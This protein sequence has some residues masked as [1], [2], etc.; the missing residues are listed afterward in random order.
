MSTIPDDVWRAIREVHE[1]LRELAEA[2]KK[3]SEEW[4]AR[5]RRTDEEI[6]NLGIHIGRVTGRW[7]RFVE[8]LLTPSLVARVKEIGFDVES[9]HRNP[10]ARNGGEKELDLV[11][12]GRMGRRTTLVIA[13]LKSRME[14]R[15]V[16]DHV[17]DIERFYDFFRSFPRADRMGAIG[18]IGFANGAERYAERRGLFVA[19]ITE[20]LCRFSN[21][22]G[23][24]PAVWRRPGR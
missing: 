10:E 16:D 1:V 15:D 24:K 20:D 22:P 2:Q 8:D 11:V 3:T 4:R 7:G 5:A 23:F 13:S 19:R 12:V 6:R 17:G 21:A 18:A 9:V 14:K